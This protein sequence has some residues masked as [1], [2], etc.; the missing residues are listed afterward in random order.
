MNDQKRTRI[1]EAE[2]F[3]D[4]TQGVDPSIT[5]KE[6][7][8]QFAQR[9][10]HENQDSAERIKSLEGQVETL[11]RQKDDAK[12]H[13]G[14][15][16]SKTDGMPPQIALPIS[17]VVFASA[18]VAGEAVFLSPVMDGFGIADPAYQLIFAAVIV[19]TTS[20]L[21]EITKQFFH[22]KSRRNDIAEEEASQ[23]EK[24]GAHGSVSL[25]FF[26]VFTTLAF[27]LVF[28]LGWWRA[29]EMIYAA[30]AQA[31]TWKDFLTNNPTLT[32]AVVVL[33]TTSLPIFV[34]MAFEWGIDGLHL[35]WEWRKSRA[36]YKRN[37]KRLDATQKALEK[38]IESKASRK[39][40]LE[41]M[42]EEWKQAYLQNHELGQKTGAWKLPL[43]RVALKIGAVVLLVLTL[44][45]VLD[46]I[47]AQYIASGG[48]R[49]LLYACLTLGVGVLYA[50]HAIRVWDRPS[51]VQLYEQKATIFKSPARELEPAPFVL[52]AD[53]SSSGN[54]RKLIESST[55]VRNPA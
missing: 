2:G 37:A 54:G 35:A 24:T 23:L 12:R 53:A 17:A 5:V 42:G 50:S 14:N 30:A 26:A 13:W 48:M 32:R 38:E 18:A 41:E 36:S 33:L 39:K 4:G 45:L 43:W 47:T 19:I 10:E 44:C 51:A 3:R 28:T 22:R 21:F 46:P 27:A 9:Q 11:Q 40:A 25:I 7:E 8:A 49:C 52:P 6:I 34:A 1:V 16:E 31:G 29:E 55:Q 15:L 20:G